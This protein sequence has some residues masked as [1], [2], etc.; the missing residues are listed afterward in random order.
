MHLK[1]PEHLKRARK[2]NSMADLVFFSFVAHIGFWPVPEVTQYA[3][4]R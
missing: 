2:G 4:P 1:M 3:K